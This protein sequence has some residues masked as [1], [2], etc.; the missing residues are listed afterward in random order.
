MDTEPTNVLL[1]SDRPSD[2]A[3]LDGALAADRRAG[4]PGFALVGRPLLPEEGLMRLAGGGIDVLLL[5]V[6]QSAEQGLDTLVRARIQAPDVPV[7]FL[8][9]PGEGEQSLG[10]QAVEAGA[11][12]V[13]SA[14]QLDGGV[15]ARVLRYAIE[16][17]HMHATLRQ[18]SLTDDLTGLYNRRGFTALCEHHLRLARRTRGLLVAAAELD[19]L[20]AIVERRGRVEGERA[21]VRAAQVLRATFRAS[22]PIARVSDGTFAVLVLDAAHETVDIVAPRL[23]AR[24][25][26]DNAAAERAGADRIALHVAL[27]RVEPDAPPDVE[28]LLAHAAAALAERKGRG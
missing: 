8:T 25:E 5:D 10:A 20:G 4:A 13:L 6:R 24:L 22:D 1:I 3:R 2:H 18:L 7:V 27:T 15:L 14:D 16:R 19:G 17:Q 23:R 28:R 21:V 11:Q 9:A 26:S 12:D